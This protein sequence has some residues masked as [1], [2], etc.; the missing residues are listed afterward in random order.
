MND[1]KED[2][3]LLKRHF[4]LYFLSQGKEK[5]RKSKRA[6]KERGDILPL[7]FLLAFSNANLKK[8]T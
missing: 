7:A 4:L 2:N 8:K 1:F 3:K 6:G 5:Q